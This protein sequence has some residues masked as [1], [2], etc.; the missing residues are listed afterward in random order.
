VPYAGAGDEQCSA[1]AG[2]ATSQQPRRRNPLEALAP[3]AVQS[4]QAGILALQAAE[5]SSK[6]KVALPHR[7]DFRS[8]SHPLPVVAGRADS[9]TSS[10]ASLDATALMVACTRADSVLLAKQRGCKERQHARHSRRLRPP[11]LELALARRH[12]LMAGA[13]CLPSVGIMDVR[14]CVC[15]CVWTCL[16]CALVWTGKPG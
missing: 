5:S 9:T 16:W 1:A 13:P 14:G 11:S 7:Q 15:K 2:L 8:T 4:S 6:S 12:E 10:E 3:A